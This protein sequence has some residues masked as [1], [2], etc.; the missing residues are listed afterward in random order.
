ALAESH[1]RIDLA[2]AVARRAIDAGTPLMVHGYP[3]TTLPTGGIAEHPLLLAIVRQESAFAP[4]A[5]SQVGARGL[6]QRMPT[7]AAGV[8]KKLALPYSLAR[9]TTD[10]LDNLVLG[11]PHRHRLFAR[12]RPR[13]L[14]LGPSGRT[15]ISPS[16]TRNAAAE[17]SERM[18]GRWKVCR[19]A[20]RGL[21]A[22]CPLVRTRLPG[23]ADA[24]RY[25][26]LS[27]R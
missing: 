6:M 18:T 23:G 20:R 14:T 1:G 15:E 7:T 2:I 24:A 25:R 3:V 16:W 21:F 8:A 27:R 19:M 11:R 26:T 10:R 9:L 13:A 4:D 12:Q 5:M 17:H 22:G